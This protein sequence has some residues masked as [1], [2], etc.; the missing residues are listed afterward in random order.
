M[1]VILVWFSFT[2]IVDARSANAG[3]ALLLVV[4]VLEPLV[5]ALPVEALPYEL[6]EPPPPPPPQ[7]VSVTVTVPRI[8]G[9]SELRMDEPLSG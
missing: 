6:S 8:I 2:E 4:V 7:A 3:A 5:P 1:V 9:I